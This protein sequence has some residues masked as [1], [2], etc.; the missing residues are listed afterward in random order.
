M[1][2]R[3]SRA[4]FKWF[5]ISLAAQVRLPRTQPRA[6]GLPRDGAAAHVEEGILPPGSSRLFEVPR[7]NYPL[8]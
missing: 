1:I 7:N 8:G 6:L 5:F 3:S 4:G 2:L